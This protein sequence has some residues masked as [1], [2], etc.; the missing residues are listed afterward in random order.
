MKLST[1]NAVAFAASISSFVQ[2]DPACQ[3]TLAV[4]NPNLRTMCLNASKH[5][6][7][8]FSMT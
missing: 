1:V 6:C 4:Y 2:A 8:G 5:S 7:L 3:N